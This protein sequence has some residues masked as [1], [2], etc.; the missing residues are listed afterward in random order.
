MPEM[1]IGTRRVGSGSPCYVIAEIGINHNGST[2]LAKEMIDAAV[3]CKVDAVK[4]QMRDLK[5]L[6]KKD[7]LTRPEAQDLSLQYTLEHV[8]RSQLTES[9]FLELARY[10]RNKGVEFLCTPWDVASVAVLERIGVPAYKVASADISNF[11]LLDT[12]IATGKPL[13]LST[14]MS[15]R[16]EIDNTYQYLQSHSV[17]FSLLHCNSTYPADVKDIHLLFM[18]KM[19]SDYAVPI[20]YS[21]HERGIMVSIAACALGASIVERHF[22]ID[23]TLPGPDHVASLEPVEFAEMVS[24]MR[25]VELAL[26]DGT[27]VLTQGIMINQQTLGKSLVAARDIRKGKRI[28]RGDV[29]VRSPGKGLSPR[30]LHEIVGSV[31]R[32]HIPADDY[33]TEEDRGVHTQQNLVHSFARP[34]GIP[35]RFHDYEIT[36]ARFHPQFVEFHLSSQDVLSPKFPADV[37]LNF[38]IHVPDLWGENFML[39]LCSPNEDER[40]Q[41]L[42]YVKK[43]MGVGQTLLSLQREPQ[44]EIRYIVHVGGFTADAPVDSQIRKIYFQQLRKSVQALMR[45][46]RKMGN[47]SRFLVENMPPLP[48]LMGG[49]RF[50]NV[51]TD[52]QEIL[53]FCARND[54][55]FCLDVSHGYLYCEY[56]KKDFYDYVAKLLPITDHL[57]ISDARGTD[58][59]GLVVG[60]GS[61]HFDILAKMLRESEKC[62][63]CPFIP[64]IWQGHTFEGR[65]FELSLQRLQEAGF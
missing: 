9:D 43:T 26:G 29:T 21:G 31:A 1:F 33:F 41:S 35:V 45:Y 13:I 61:I 36:V 55:G 22:T 8:Q 53:A 18:R 4:F 58:G 62:A 14:G 30:Y 51:M 37:G 54:V 49:Q 24:H 48:W 28:M 56:A 6:Y 47:K 59:E 52:E 57:H 34:W 20:G 44:K 60:E 25:T 65:G 64:E 2:I 10:S 23:R 7:V 50:S 5:A 39:N 19:M 12:L 63:Q 11:E 17:S 46:A 27:K 16:D 15:K 40:Q 38:T 42:D 3:A 32:R